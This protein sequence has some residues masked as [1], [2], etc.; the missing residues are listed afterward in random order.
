MSKVHP[1]NWEQQ[2]KMEQVMKKMGQQVAQ[3]LAINLV[4]RL[5]DHQEQLLKK[6]QSNKH[7]A[8]IKSAAENF[9]SMKVVKLF[10]M[11]LFCMP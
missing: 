11:T 2:D 5:E 6:L 1:V 7:K 4:S 8:K 3:H 9:I 10:F